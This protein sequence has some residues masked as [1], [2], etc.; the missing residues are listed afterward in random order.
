M[1]ALSLATLSALAQLFTAWMGWRVTIRP[2][3]EKDKRKHEIVFVIVGLIGVCFLSFGAYFAAQ[4]QKKLEIDLS[5]LKKAQQNVDA[6]I[7]QANAGIAII[8]QKVDTPTLNANSLNKSSLPHTTLERRS[9]LHISKFELVPPAAGKPIYLNVNF[10]NTGLVDAEMKAYSLVTLVV[11]SSDVSQQIKIEDS[12]FE[13]LAD[14]VKND[15]SVPHAISPGSSELYFTD[16]GPVLSREDV[17]SF[18]SGRYAAYF[19]GKI[20]YADPAGSRETTY[21]VYISGYPNALHLCRKHNQE[22]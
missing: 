15:G 20:I 1:L 19:V 2:P 6:G 16:A 21:C 11:T 8:K 12:L 13:S 22:Q 14:V 3:G 17:E 4:D 18:V 7:T 5:D 10:Q 9:R